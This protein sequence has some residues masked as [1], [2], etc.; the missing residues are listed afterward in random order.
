MSFGAKLWCKTRD[1]GI[2]RLVKVI[3]VRE[4][5]CSDEHIKNKEMKKKM[6]EFRKYL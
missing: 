3:P 5:S 2:F 6:G 4:Y 1:K